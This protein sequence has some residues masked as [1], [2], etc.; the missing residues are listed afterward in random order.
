MKSEKNLRTI[1][2]E[3]IRF[4][5]PLILSGVLQQLYNWVDAFIV[6][7]VTGELALSAIGAAGIP[8]NLFVT[9]IT[10]FTLG[11]SVLAATYYGRRETERLA[12]LLSTFSVLLGCVF[13]AVAVGASFFAY[14]FM[15]LLHTP[16]DTIGAASSYV[17]LIAMGFPFLAVYNVY[18]ATLRGM[19]DSRIPFLSILVFSGI[20]II[21]DCIL[22]IGF[23]LGV[24]GAALATV[25][26]QAGMTIFL[27]AYGTRKYPELC[28]RV[29]KG[30]LNRESL[31]EGL[32]FGMPT[33]I[34]SSVSAL[35][36][37]V[38]QDFMNRF[39]THTVT[40]ITTAYRIDTLVML[41]I[42]NLGSGISTMTAHS[43]AAGDEKGT[44]HIFSA[45]MILTG[46]VSCLLTVLVIPT[47]GKMIALFGAGTE[48]VRIGSAFFVRLACFYPVYGFSMAVRGFL[49]GK[50][51]LVCSSVIGISCLIIRILASYAMVGAFGNMTIAYAEMFAWA[52]QL[53]LYLLRMLTRKEEKSDFILYH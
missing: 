32:K 11:L 46:A 13:A 18:S 39:G 22:V 25:F 42:T 35:G 44:R 21:A 33:M 19:G 26:S 45:G 31:A 9:A 15:A 6:G 40:A 3:L 43:H 17:R 37:L 2:K 20:N 41:P 16:A 51:D 38:L 14:P 28:F 34:Q 12:P 29:G 24:E 47:G 30:L 50:G 53:A 27:V 4:C 23:G 36:S 5:L 8:V 48:A 52:V 1:M 7:N 49:E 10:G